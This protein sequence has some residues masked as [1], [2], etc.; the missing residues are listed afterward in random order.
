MIEMRLT[1][2]CGV[3]ISALDFPLSN[4]RF[5][6]GLHG[7][8][9]PPHR[10]SSG[11]MKQAVQMIGNLATS[12]RKRFESRWTT[13]HSRVPLAHTPARENRLPCARLSH[14]TWVPKS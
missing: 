6:P 5:Q 4:G 12:S 11:G 1:S 8:I 9:P 14:E 10:A 3:R 13:C 2:W 7:E